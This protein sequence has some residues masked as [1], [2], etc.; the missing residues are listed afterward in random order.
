MYDLQMLRVRRGL[1]RNETEEQRKKRLEK[2]R[3]L[4]KAAYQKNK[5]FAK[6]KRREQYQEAKNKLAEQRKQEKEKARAERISSEIQKNLAKEAELKLLITK[7]SDL[8]EKEEPHVVTP[9]RNAP[10]LVLV[11]DN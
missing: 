10:K 2:Q 7:A 8:E 9:I 1:L 4:R 3:E 11:K 6:K 5:E